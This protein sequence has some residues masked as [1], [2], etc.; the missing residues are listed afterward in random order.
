[1]NWHMRTFSRENLHCL[2][3]RLAKRASRV[4]SVMI[5]TVVSGCEER[6]RCRKPM[7]VDPDSHKGVWNFLVFS[8]RN[9]SRQEVVTSRYYWSKTQKSPSMSQKDSCTSKKRGII[10]DI[11]DHSLNVAGVF[12][13]VVGILNAYFG[14]ANSGSA[15][16]SAT[17]ILIGNILVFR[18]VIVRCRCGFPYSLSWTTLHCIS[19]N[20]CIG[21]I[22]SRLPIEKS[23]KRWNTADSIA[24]AAR[25]EHS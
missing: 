5:L 22:F 21:R 6:I 1:M 3:R 2:A 13:V 25:R 20:F 19:R 8:R 10:F 7:E 11:Q 17:V 12:L 23:C 14:S 16:S 4:P 15:Y 24:S 9:H 18:C